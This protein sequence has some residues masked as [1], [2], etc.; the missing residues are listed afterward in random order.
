MMK[1]RRTRSLKTRRLTLRPPAQWVAESL[2]SRVFLAAVNWTGGGGDSQWTN[3][4]NWS[5]NPT[6][7]GASDDVTINVVGVPPIQIS[8]GTQAV[9]SITCSNSLVVAGG[10]LSVSATSQI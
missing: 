7:P 6:L 2:E 1:S 3:P 9:N 5:S 4:L 8:S 10:T